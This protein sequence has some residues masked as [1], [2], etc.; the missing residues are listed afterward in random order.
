MRLCLFVLLLLSATPLLVA[1]GERSA[2]DEITKV[3]KQ[4]AADAEDKDWKSVCD[5][6]SADAEAEVVAVAET[7][8]GGDC[9]AVIARLYA[10]DDHPEMLPTSGGEGVTVSDV[11]VS[12]DRA[13]A[14]VEPAFPGD[15]PRV[16][17]V[18]ENG[19]WKLDADL[20]G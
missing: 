9:A 15:N 12:G 18:R 3:T 19:A 2:D 6:M 16:H 11:K 17:Y 1:C 13:T 4:F 8:G 7:L 5:A 20:G 14:K 10:L